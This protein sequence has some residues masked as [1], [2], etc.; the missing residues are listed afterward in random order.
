MRT[1]K[2]DQTDLV[3]QKAWEK[4][5]ENIRMDEILEIF[6]YERVKKQMAIYLRVLPEGQKILE[7]GCGLAPY[8]IKLRQ[9]G[10]DVEGIDY[11]KEPIDKVLAFDPKLPVR[12]GDVTAIPY[13]DGCFG[14]YISLGV[15]EHFTEGPVK[16]I[17]EAWRVLKPGGVFVVAVPQNHLFMRIFAPL[18]ILKE[19]AF[20][21][22]LFGKPMDTHYWEQY[23]NK[24]EL[25]AVFMREGFEVREVHPM[26]HSAAVMCLSKSFR[27]KKTFDEA[28]PLGLRIGRWCEKY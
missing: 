3:T 7:G 10:Y 24:D 27:D 19:N 4:N 8:L 18:R 1:Q 5:W 2:N 23:F 6:S 25:R 14:G 12:V 9:L 11:N 21:R 17:R 28:S 20:L 16:A 22:R 15:I 13:P 26:D